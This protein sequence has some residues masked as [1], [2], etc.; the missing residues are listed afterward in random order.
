VTRLRIDIETYSS[1]DLTKT[2]VYRYA[3]SPDFMILFAWWNVDDGPVTLAYSQEE[4]AAIPGLTDPGV[5]KVAQ[6]SQFER[7]CFS[8][9]LGLPPGVYLPPEEWHD[10]QAVA[11]EYGW[12]QKLENLARALGVE[13][14][15]AAGTRLINMFCKPNRQGRRTL[16]EEKPMEW[17]DF[18]AYGE[19]DVY[20]LIEVDEALGDH[21]TP[22]E[23]EVFLADQRINDRGICID[24]DMARAAVVSANLNAEAAKARVTELTGVDNPNSQPQ[25]MAWC[26]EQGLSITNLRAETVSDL[27]GTDLS[28]T[29]QEVFE[30]RQELALV[31]SKK[32]GSALNAVSPDGRLRGT[33]KFFGAHTGR[34]AGRGTQ[35]HN[36]PRLAFEKINS[37]TGK[38]EWDKD[39]EEAAILDLVHLDAGATPPTLKK[40]VRSLFTGPF[41]VVDYSS[42]E[43]VVI[44]WLSGEE[45]A[46]QAFRDGR[47]I[48]VETAER[49]STP[50]HLLDRSQGKIAVLALGYAGG[51]N[52]LRAMGAE[53]SDIE[54]DRLVKQWRRANRNIVD[55]W[56]GLD[57][58]FAETGKVGEFLELSESQ[59]HL[60]RVVQMRLP[61][62][63]AISYHGVKWERYP[64][65][66]A[67]TGLK[68][69]KTSWRYTD[70]KQPRS[71]I[72]TYGG[73]LSENATQAV[74]RDILAEAL[75]RLHNH[76]YN[77]VAHVHDEIVVEGEHDVEIIKKLMC[78]LPDWAKDLPIDGEGFTCQ[79][80]RKG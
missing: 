49:M 13:E 44:A 58:A 16:P 38:K 11:G 70:P 4:I 77:V 53:G 64:V 52:S 32:Y 25:M 55:L 63:R 59:D 31:A 71:R 76:G 57:E 26:R 12:P 2:G 29:H 43:A 33:L 41:T 56:S 1:V 19:Q 7:V 47:D 5:L 46:L 66:D 40:L 65:I 78:E 3:E 24:L 67:R 21:I 23:L 61:S 73:R 6:N 60:G 69:I 72:P 34:W 62:G 50:G 28:P 27:L 20:T 75:V 36:L 30:L 68:K 9:F 14:K 17:L 22:T 54:L 45:W 18:L 10:T 15:D 42:I 48:Y 35:V 79:R 37:A 8:N 80:Y 74:A 51:I 39:A